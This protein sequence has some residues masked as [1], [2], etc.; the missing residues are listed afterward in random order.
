MDAN[1]LVEVADHLGHAKPA[2]RTVGELVQAAAEEGRNTRS[3]AH[4]SLRRIGI[5][6]RPG[7]VDISCTHQELAKIY[8]D[9]PWSKKWKDQFLRIKGARMNDNAKFSGVQHRTV[10]VPLGGILGKIGENDAENCGHEA[11]EDGEIGH[12]EPF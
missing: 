7:E 6:V 5:A 10:R 8:A 3:Q 4:A 9:T 12:V 2:R 11:G 1:V